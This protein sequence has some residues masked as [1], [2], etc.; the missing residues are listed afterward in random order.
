MTKTT[1]KQVLEFTD[2]MMV[3]YSKDIFPKIKQKVGEFLNIQKETYIKDFL[4]IIKLTVMENIIM[5]MV[6]NILDIGMMIFNVELDMKF[7]EIIQD[8]QE[9]FLKEK[10]TV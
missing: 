1:S 7:G 6:L 8:I 2:I 5:K 10:N 3:V 4:K 9:N